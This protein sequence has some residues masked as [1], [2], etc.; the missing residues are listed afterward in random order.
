MLISQM[1]GYFENPYYRYV[2]FNG[3]KIK[4]VIKIISVLRE[5]PT[6][7]LPQSMPKGA[8]VHSLSARE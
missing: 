8:T 4:A 5:K 7:I 6:H 1:K 2:I 3:F